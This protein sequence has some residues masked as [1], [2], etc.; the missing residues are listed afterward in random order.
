VIKPKILLADTRYDAVGAHSN[1]VSIGIGCIGP[2]LKE[3]LKDYDI[4]LKFST[5]PEEVFDLIDSLKPGAIC[6]S[7]YIWNSNLSNSIC[8]KEFQKVN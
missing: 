1:Y 4:D 5:K 6:L 2:Y 7:N 3:K 8:E